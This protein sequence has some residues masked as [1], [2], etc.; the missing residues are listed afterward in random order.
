MLGLALD[1]PRDRDRVHE[2]EGISFIIDDA[3]YQRLQPN[4]P[5]RV[6]Y[7][8]RLLNGLRV[9]ISRSQASCG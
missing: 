4:L 3:L 6:D 1:E 7:D 5:L 9:R 8:D 2:A